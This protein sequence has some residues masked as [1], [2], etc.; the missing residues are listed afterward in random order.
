[1]GQ[2]ETGCDSDYGCSD[3]DRFHV[4][5]FSRG[6]PAESTVMRRGRYRTAPLSAA[7]GLNDER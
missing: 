7:D 6:A 3:G 1:V 5:A 4:S 2:D